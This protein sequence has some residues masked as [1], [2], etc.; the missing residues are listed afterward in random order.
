MSIIDS[1]ILW[2]QYMRGLPSFNNTFL[3]HFSQSVSDT[4]VL[5]KFNEDDID[6]RWS[7][8]TR[9]D[10]QNSTEL[11]PNLRDIFRIHKLSNSVYQLPGD[12]GTWSIRTGASGSKQFVDENGH[13]LIGLYADI[14]KSKMEIQSYSKIVIDRNTATPMI[15]KLE[16]PERI[17]TQCKDMGT[18]SYKNLMTYLST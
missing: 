7:K 9:Q 15:F 16:C 13:M 5:Y 6:M 10:V 3:F 14:D 11:P 2:Y 4:V 18:F 1:N 17:K 12:S 8:L